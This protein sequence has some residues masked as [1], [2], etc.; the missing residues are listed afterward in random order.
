VILA[1]AFWAYRT[2]RERSENAIPAAQPAPSIAPAGEM[3]AVAAQ[4]ES[5]PPAATPGQASA[6]APERGRATSN[7]STADTAALPTVRV[8]LSF[9]ADSWVELYD[10]NERR[11]FFELGV[12]N[13]ARS[14]T[15]ATPARIFLGYADAVQVEVDG[16]PVT[17]VDSVR[18][19]NVAHFSID[20]RGR[21]KPAGSLSR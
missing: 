10:A 8:R 15:V 21:V 9:S 3:P 6:E 2:W 14:F 5:A 12:A 20:A 19:G 11:V 4:S 18:R 17:L 13:T 7:A 16:R 1:G